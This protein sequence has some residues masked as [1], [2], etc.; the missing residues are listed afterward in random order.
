MRA[1]KALWEPLDA[2]T[3]QR[4]VAEIKSLRRIEPPYTN[5]LLFA[6]MNEAWLLSIGEEFDPMRMNVAIRKI[7]EWYVR[8]R[9]DQGR[10]GFHFDYYNSYVMYPM[11]VEILDVLAEAQGSPFWNGK[12]D[13]LLAQASS[14]CSATASTW[15]AS[16]APT[17]A[18][19][20]SAAR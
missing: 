16:S 13:E 19:R 9:L 15:N 7:N 2:T 11:L 20:P 4:I 14:A 5:W 3:K 17:A 1:P 6:A 18:I 8:R 12:P 10:R